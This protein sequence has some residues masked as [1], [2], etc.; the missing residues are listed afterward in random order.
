M[1]R[2][3]RAV[4]ACTC[5]ILASVLVGAVFAQRDHRLRT[6]RTLNHG[7]D[8]CSDQQGAF[9]R[10]ARSAQSARSAAP[11]GKQ[12]RVLHH[13]PR[14]WPADPGNIRLDRQ[15]QA[16]RCGGKSD[17]RRSRVG[18]L[19]PR[20]VTG[21][22]YRQGPGRRV[23]IGIRRVSSYR[24]CVSVAG[25]RPGARSRR[26]A[27]LALPGGRARGCRHS[28]AA[29]RRRAAFPRCVDDVAYRRCASIR[30]WIRMAG[31]RSSST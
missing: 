6:V 20:A 16:V 5:S 17:R 27:R 22:F 21:E 29:V 24:R 3:W 12:G 26:P 18:E 10:A 9:A 30:Y 31:C 28:G 14:T 7:H 11:D 8:A 25:Q 1:R 23:R 2:L 19:S 15:W 13:L 4:S